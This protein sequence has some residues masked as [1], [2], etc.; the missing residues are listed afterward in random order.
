MAAPRLHAVDS[1][2]SATDT[3]VGIPAPM[4]ANLDSPEE[5]V[6]DRRDYKAW[7]G[8]REVFATVLRETLDSRR[9]AAAAWARKLGVDPSFLGRWT[10]GQIVKSPY[11]PDLLLMRE[12]D[13]VGFLRA[14]IIRVRSLPP[15]SPAALLDTADDLVSHAALV[16]TR[17]RA[18][19]KDGRIDAAEETEFHTL[20]DALDDL[21]LRLRA[22]RRS[23]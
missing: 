15:L 1:G 6:G 16:L 14:L 13:L 4:A 18:A 7:R 22:V 21:S 20:A 10:L 9:G 8:A 3:E 17:S 2:D 19:L 23:P 11:G 12:D 5:V